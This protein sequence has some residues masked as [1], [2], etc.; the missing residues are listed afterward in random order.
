MLVNRI[1]LQRGAV[2]ILAV[3]VVWG[4][5]AF[6]PDRQV[7]KAFARFLDA[8]SSRNWKKVEGMMT[9]E[10]RDQWGCDRETA[11]HLGSEAFQHYI[12]LQI[13][14]SDVKVVRQGSQA[15]LSA[16]L[17]F[18]GRGSPVGEL[19]TQQVNGLQEEFRFAWKR[20]SWKPWDWKLQS[21]SEPEIN[22]DPA[23]MP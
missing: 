8:A 14:P 12:F 3:L 20:Q 1:W 10:Y 15:T 7:K 13:V 18:T 2:G 17:K 23:S 16:R 11:V 4:L 5:Y 19:I 6:S 22:F 21:I 9:P